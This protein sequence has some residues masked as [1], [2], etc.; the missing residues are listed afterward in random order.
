MIKVTYNLHQL[1]N[2]EGPFYEVLNA[3]KASTLS[4]EKKNEVLGFEDLY[5]EQEDLQFFCSKYKDS[6]D[7]QYPFWYVLEAVA[8]MC[9]ASWTNELD[10]FGKQVSN[11]ECHA[12]EIYVKTIPE[13]L[14]KQVNS[15]FPGGAIQSEEAITYKTF[16]QWNQ[17]GSAK[18]VAGQ[19]LFSLRVNN[20]RPSLQ[21]CLGFINWARVFDPSIELITKDDYLEIT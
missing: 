15:V 8:Q 12:L 16:E 17:G 2:R 20:A 18:H 7:N 21:F 14:S 1:W 10:R 6:K 5:I 4:T 13:L 9:M 11:I 3:L 19:T